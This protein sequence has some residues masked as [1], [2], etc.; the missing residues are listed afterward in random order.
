MIHFSGHK[1]VFRAPYYPVDSAI[2]H[3]FNV[4][5]GAIRQGMYRIRSHEDVVDEFFACM[6]NMHSFSEYFAH[7]GIN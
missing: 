6:R 2:K 7:V 1:C 3:V 5:Q 4:V